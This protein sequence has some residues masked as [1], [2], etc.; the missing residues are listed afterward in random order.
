MSVVFETDDQ[1]AKR[2]CAVAAELRT[3][4]SRRRAVELAAEV[5]QIA[6]ILDPPNEAPT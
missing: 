6:A 5:D 3:L 1:L 2:L 4:V